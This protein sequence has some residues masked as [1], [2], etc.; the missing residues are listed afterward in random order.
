MKFFQK[1]GLAKRRKK[2][3][4]QRS[5]SVTIRELSSDTW[6]ADSAE[7]GVYLGLHDKK[8]GS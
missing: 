5:L 4:A 2:K 1:A 8:E 3:E 7:M 6:V